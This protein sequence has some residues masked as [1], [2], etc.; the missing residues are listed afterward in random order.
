[1][2][3]TVVAA[4]AAVFMVCGLYAQSFP[5]YLKM[6]GTMIVGCDKSSLPANLVIPD[7]VT[8]IRN[9]FPSCENLTSVTIPG[10]VMFIGVRA[11]E[12]C[13]ELTSI[14]IT[15]GV[16]GIGWHAFDGCYKLTSVTI[17]KSVTKIW[18]RAFDVGLKMVRYTGTKAQWKQI[19]KAENSFDD[20]VIVRCSDGD[21]MWWE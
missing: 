14:I 2:K 9:A 12:D 20:Y 17:P 21:I 8:I 19:S 13:G 7:G 16:R 10:S 4:L 11:F 1:M 5:A 15:E 18:E 3:K 6:D